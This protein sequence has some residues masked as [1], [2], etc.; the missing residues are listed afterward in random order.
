MQSD[1]RRGPG[2]GP[3]SGAG[4]APAPK[5][6]TEAAAGRTVTPELTYTGVWPGGREAGAKQ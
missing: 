1:G 3:G 4:Q 2:R 5:A 6:A